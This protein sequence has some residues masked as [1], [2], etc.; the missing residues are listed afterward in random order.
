MEGRGIMDSRYRTLNITSLTEVEA[1]IDFLLDLYLK[2]DRIPTDDEEK[3]VLQLI[4]VAKSL[5]SRRIW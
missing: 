5:G 4:G 3:Q 2:D 1:E